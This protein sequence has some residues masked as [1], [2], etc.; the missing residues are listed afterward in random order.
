M[1]MSGYDA[2]VI[3]ISSSNCVADRSICVTVTVGT[4]LVV[5]HPTTVAYASHAPASCCPP[6]DAVTAT[7]GTC[8][9]DVVAPA[10]GRRARA[11][12]FFGASA[13]GS[14]NLPALQ[15]IQT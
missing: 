1:V 2:P 7:D 10:D 11:T 3:G 12:L 6:T 9:T 5:G 4:L 14:L 13:K 15:G 8:L